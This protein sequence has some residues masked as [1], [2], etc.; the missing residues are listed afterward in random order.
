MYRALLYCYYYIIIVCARVRVNLEVL[1]CH[2]SI[3][4]SV[5][6][7][8]YASVSP[9][10]SHLHIIKFCNIY[11]YI[12]IL[13]HS[14]SFVYI[15][16]R[17]IIYPRL[18]SFLLLSVCISVSLLR[19]TRAHMHS[20]RG[21]HVTT[22]QRR[23]SLSANRYRKRNKKPPIVLKPRHRDRI[24]NTAECKLVFIAKTF[25]TYLLYC[26]NSHSNKLLKH[27]H[28]HTR[29]TPR[30]IDLRQNGYY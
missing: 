14:R 21:G 23:F 26:S 24:G 19:A 15:D 6:F 10:R 30:A 12:V 7:L 17:Y 18:H 5:S 1:V 3:S 8:S 22:A 29:P 9:S 2:C 27:T 25:Y 28:T 13:S 11:I 4:L 20:S 16:Y